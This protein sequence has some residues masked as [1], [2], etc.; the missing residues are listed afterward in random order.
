MPMGIASFDVFDTC[1]IRLVGRPESLFLLLG[2]SLRKMNIWPET[3][4]EFAFARQEAERRARRNRR[5]QEVQ[6]SDIYAEMAHMFAL[7]HELINQIETAECALESI[8]LRPV[9][10]AAQLVADARQQGKRV[11]YISDTYFPPPLLEDWLTRHGFLAPQQGDQIVASCVEGATKASGDI[12]PK[13]LSQWLMAPSQ[14]QHTGDNEQSD[15]RI[16]ARLGVMVRHFTSTY[17]SRYEREM[18][19]HAAGTGGLASIFAGTSRYL[20]VC[21]LPAEAQ[22]ALATQAELACQVAAPVLAAFVLWVLRRAKHLGLRRL[23]FVS[24]DGQVM[25]RIAR[26]IAAKLGMTIEMDYLYAGRQVVN[27][28]GLHQVD[29]AA[30]EWITES[31]ANISTEELLKRV[32]LNSQDL[33]SLI[34]AYGLNNPDM[35]GRT[36]IEAIRRFLMDP[37]VTALILASA[38]RRRSLLKDYYSHCGLMSGESVGIVDIG[39]K[40]RVFKAIAEI[41][42]SEAAALH[43]SFYFGLFRR[44]DPAPAGRMEAFIF[45]TWPER[46]LG[47]ARDL[48]IIANLMEIFCQ[49]DHGQV[50]SVEPDVGGYQPILRNQENYCGAHWDVSLQQ[51]LLEDFARELPVEFVGAI[52]SDLRAMCHNL[53][54]LLLNRPTRGEAV[55]LGSFPYNDDQNGAVMHP[56]V[57]GYRI[58]DLRRAFV[59]GEWPELS[60]PWWLAGARRLTHPLLLRGIYVAVLLGSWRGGLLPR[61]AFRIKTLILQRA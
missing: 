36:R 16:P 25:L 54:D 53:L 51:K 9:A 10:P 61:L 27:L 19:C 14:L 60:T 42:G 5:S 22:G 46:N 7:T 45:D 48:P 37:Q 41:I 2:A 24:R 31:A 15:V 1:L 32:D 28:G 47:A 57:V 49:A 23:L 58:R 6:L 13:L 56:L 30:I 59:S 44:P 20:R 29:A 40:G 50:M 17:L 34:Q 3:N 55:L 39:W 18:E 12:F 8:L 52:D 11:A 4:G 35:K 33:A 26:P 38:Q 43:T 21:K